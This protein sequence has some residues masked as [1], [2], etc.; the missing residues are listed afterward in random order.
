MNVDKLVK[1]GIK[2]YQKNDFQESIKSYQ[3]ALKI[4]SNPKD[5]A[6]IYYNIGLSY[7][8]LL[9]YRE[10]KKEFKKSF[11]LGYFKAG[12]EL[13]MSKLHLG[14]IDGMD[15]FSYR[16]FG[17]PNSFPNLPIKKII[18]IEDIQVANKILVLNEQ[19][20]GDEILF[21]RGISLI[22]D[23]DFSYQVYP[24]MLNLFQQNFQGNFF[25]DRNLSYDFVMEHDFWIP[26]GDLFKLKTSRGDFDFNHFQTKIGQKNKIGICF[27][28][29]ILSQNSLSRS[30]NYDILR[31]KLLKFP[32]LKW[33]SLQKDFVMDFA[34]NPTINDFTDTSNIIDDLDFVVTVDTVIAHL[35]AIKNKK[36]YLLHNEY[37]DWRWNFPFYGNNIQP[38]KFC[39]L[40]KIFQ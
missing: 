23:K 19:G 9:K 8:S 10:S 36:V 22:K 40:E 25:S 21:S 17:K 37:L 14:E 6:T 15:Y 35:A 16:Y 32:D 31:N 4:C 33:V 27:K 39:D 13:S 30:V 1:K 24:E 11:D 29:N 5:L 2:E 18:S 3:K 28:T 12:W 7:Y 26:S 20:F 38:I 34:E